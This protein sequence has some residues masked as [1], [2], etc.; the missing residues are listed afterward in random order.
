MDHHDFQKWMLRNRIGVSEFA[1]ITG[2]KASQIRLMLKG[3]KKIDF[4]LEHQLREI[5]N[6]KT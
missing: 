2:M 3:G 5:E 4:A 1:R 6:G